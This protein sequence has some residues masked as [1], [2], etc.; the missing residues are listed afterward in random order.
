[1]SFCSIVKEFCRTTD[2]DLE[3][4]Q[5]RAGEIWRRARRL[6]S[7]ELPAPMRSGRKSPL[8]DPAR[9]LLFQGMSAAAYVHDYPASTQHEYVCRDLQKLCTKYGSQIKAAE[10]FFGQRHLP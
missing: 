1:M 8:G 7:A 5:Q 9:D 3:Q 4:R 6:Y 10:R 2:A